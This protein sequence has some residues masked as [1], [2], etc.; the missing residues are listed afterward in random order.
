MIA[1][2]TIN[3]LCEEAG[4]DP[5]RVIS[6]AIHPCEVTFTVTSMNIYGERMANAERTEVITHWVKV[7]VS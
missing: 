2:S 1:L 6:I 4:I 5:S 3:A 7:P